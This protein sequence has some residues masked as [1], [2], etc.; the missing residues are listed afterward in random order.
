MRST[1]ALLFASLVLTLAGC[2]TTTKLIANHP[3]IINSEQASHA[4]VY[5]LREIPERS[6][7]VAD[8][9]LRIEIGKQPLLSLAQ[10]EYSLIRLKPG[11]YDI[12]I[13]SRTSLTTN[14]APV[15]VW[16]A[17]PFDFV[18]GESYYIHTKAFQEEWRGFYYVPESIGE[19]EA[20]SMARVMTAAGELTQAQ[21]L[22]I[23]P[24]PAPAKSAPRDPIADV[25]K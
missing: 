5:F 13:F 15:E 2:S 20:K 8:D 12:V 7:G 16:R 21:P 9:N 11:Q 24:T 22:Y 18:A 3:A 23:P 6:R 19:T 14:P 17:R 10:G 25:L 1:L 4:K